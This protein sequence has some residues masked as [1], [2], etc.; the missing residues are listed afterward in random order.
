MASDLPAI[1]GASRAS[2]PVKHAAQICRLLGLEPSPSAAACGVFRRIA[3]IERPVV[4]PSQHHQGCPEMRPASPFEKYFPISF[5]AVF[6]GLKPLPHGPKP[7][8][9][10]LKTLAR[11]QCDIIAL[12]HKQGKNRGPHRNFFQRGVPYT[13]LLATRYSCASTE[14]P[15]HVSGVSGRFKKA[16]G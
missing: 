15:V 1:T 7:R 3:I 12:R 10:A 6:T 16:H 4:K 9:Y 5:S 14:F 8:F 13:A 11:Y 2:E